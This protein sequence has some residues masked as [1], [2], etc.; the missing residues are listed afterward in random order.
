[1]TWGA[2]GVPLAD[3]MYRPLTEPV[4]AWHFNMRCPPEESGHNTLDLAFTSDGIFNAVLFWYTLQLTPD[5]TISS[6]PVISNG[7]SGVWVAAHTVAT[8]GLYDCSLPHH[9]VQ[10]CPNQQRP[11]VTQQQGS[12][13]LQAHSAQ[14]LYCQ[15]FTTYCA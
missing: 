8:F 2:A 4:E 5:I 7:C 14:R 9:S 15:R 6:A 10:S 3:G 12:S 11:S 1:M 13:K